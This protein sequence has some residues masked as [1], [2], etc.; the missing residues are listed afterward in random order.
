MLGTEQ[1]LDIGT[2][3]RQRREPEVQ[4]MP[5]S[6]LSGVLPWLYAFCPSSLKTKAVW[7]DKKKRYDEYMDRDLQNLPNSREKKSRNSSSRT[8]QHHRVAS[9][10]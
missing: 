10:H 9:L 5:N 7:K 3:A 4:Q 2:T 8:L 6:W 1:A